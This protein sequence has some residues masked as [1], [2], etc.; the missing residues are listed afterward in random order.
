MT[1]DH[2]IVTIERQLKNGDKLQKFIFARS[3]DDTRFFIHLNALKNENL[4]SWRELR[5][6]SKLAIIPDWNNIEEEKDIV[7][8]EG[9][10]LSI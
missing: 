1:D 4:N 7:A 3:D 5:S 9:F 2:I 10:I 8:K 6:G